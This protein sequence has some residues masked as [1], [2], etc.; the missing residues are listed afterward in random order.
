[1]QV[2]SHEKDIA[3]IINYSDNVPHQVIGDRI[4][5]RQVLFN[6]VSNAVKFTEQ[7][8]V[9]LEVEMQSQL[10]NK[11]NIRI[12]VTDTGI[13]IAPEHQSFIFQQFQQADSSTTR[14]F[15]GSGLG[16][17]ICQQL[18]ALMGGEIGVLSTPGEGS[19]FWFT[20]SLQQAEEP[21]ETTT[22]NANAVSSSDALPLTSL[23]VLLVEDNEINQMVAL[24]ILESLGCEIVIANHGQEAC[25]LVK[26]QRFDLIL[27]DCQMP[28]MDGFSATQVIRQYE[29]DHG[30]KSV[31][32]IALTANAIQ[33]DREKCLAAGMD[34]YLA[35]PVQQDIMQEKLTV[36]SARYQGVSARSY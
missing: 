34:D 35:K 20:L 19:T 9:S 10:E 30:H 5:I 25:E 6:L 3:L 21:S 1:M 16:L 26:T 23:K 8:Q 18:T 15:G 14:K 22:S 33:G 11:L 28:V 27:M 24:A 29:Q 7:G 17:T 32:I 12:A 4:R 13:G 31:P 2:K 36:W